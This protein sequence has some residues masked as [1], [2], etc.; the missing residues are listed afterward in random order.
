[1]PDAD[2]A[3]SHEV[4]DKDFD[5]RNFALFASSQLLSGEQAALIKRLSLTFMQNPDL[6]KAFRRPRLRFAAN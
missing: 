3:Q 1:M 5:P 6:L 4:A 2:G